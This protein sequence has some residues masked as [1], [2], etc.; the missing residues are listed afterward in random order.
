MSVKDVGEFIKR[1]RRVKRSF[2]ILE[3]NE[4]NEQF[5]RNMNRDV[6]RNSDV[7]KKLVYRKTKYYNKKLVI[8]EGDA[9]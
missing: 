3:N 9:S 2:F 7:G 8:G 6:N 5:G 1:K 4:A